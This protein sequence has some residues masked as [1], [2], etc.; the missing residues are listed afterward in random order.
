MPSKKSKSVLVLPFSRLRLKHVP[1]VGGKN[2]SLG[3][4]IHS[5]QPRGIPIPGR[6]CDYGPGLLGVCGC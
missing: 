6:F 4:M 5:L 3:E 1:L 2:A